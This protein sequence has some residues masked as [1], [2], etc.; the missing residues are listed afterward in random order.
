M[1]YAGGVVRIRPG[2]TY[3]VDKAG[4]VLVGWHGTYD[5][6]CDME[7]YAMI[8]KSVLAPEHHI[9]LHKSEQ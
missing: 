4:A 8:E 7:G 1:Y 2:D 9:Y 5:P 3:Y 6:P